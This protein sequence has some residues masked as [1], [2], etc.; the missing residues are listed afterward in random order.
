MTLALCTNLTFLLCLGSFSWKEKAHLW[1]LISLGTLFIVVYTR[2]WQF[3][4][5]LIYIMSVGE[6]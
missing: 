3:F 2:K 1:V 5:F 6:R 4:L